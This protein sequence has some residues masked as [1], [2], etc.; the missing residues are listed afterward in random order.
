MHAWPW[1]SSPNRSRQDKLKSAD[2][3]MQ[4]SCPDKNTYLC[5]ALC[6]EREHLSPS[7]RPPSGFQNV[8]PWPSQ[9]KVKFNHQRSH[10][11]KDAFLAGTLKGKAASAPRSPS[12]GPKRTPNQYSIAEA[13]LHRLLVGLKDQKYDFGMQIGQVLRGLS[14]AY[15]KFWSSTMF[16][17]CH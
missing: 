5:V 7:R 10:H 11:K 12:R 4:W 15:V 13:C 17:G 1:L 3:F 2:M 14:N 16:E 6:I 9:S 8:L